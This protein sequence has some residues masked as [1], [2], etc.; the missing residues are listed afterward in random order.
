[1]AIQN[2]QSVGAHLSVSN[3]GSATIAA[4]GAGNGLF[5]GV[6]YSTSG[7]S[8]VTISVTDNKSNSYVLVKNEYSGTSQWGLSLFYCAAPTAGVTTVSVSGGAGWSASGGFY[9][10]EFSGL[11]FTGVDASNGAFFSSGTSNPSTTFT[12]THSGDLILGY[13]A[14]NNGLST[15]S[16]FTGATFNP[17]VILAMEW[18]QQA[19]AGSV[20]VGWTA[21]NDTNFKAIVAA[22]FYG[23]A[24]SGAAPSHLLGC[25]GCGG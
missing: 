23:T 2:V 12:T 25:C 6:L 3:A 16:G 9:V 13:V 5:V 7:S 19:S 21:S 20:T 22:G 24:V 1:M 18:Q 10:S 15:G 11:T 17:G 14:S 8:N 4:S